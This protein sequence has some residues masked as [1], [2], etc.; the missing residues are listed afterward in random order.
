MYYLCMCD[1]LR[2]AQNAL[3]GRMR[4]AGRS[5]ATSVL[6]DSKDQDESPRKRSRSL[7]LLSLN[8]SDWN[9]Y[10]ETKSSPL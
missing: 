5:L 2:A 9:N 10:W 6:Y 1:C 7:S 3:A 8:S 4:F